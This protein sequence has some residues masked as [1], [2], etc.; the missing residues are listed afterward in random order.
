MDAAPSNKTTVVKP[1]VDPRFL[2]KEYG[3][4]GNDGEYFDDVYAE[5]VLDENGGSL[6]VGMHTINLNYEDILYS[7]QVVYRLA[8]GS[9]F[10]APRHGNPSGAFSVNIRLGPREHVTRLEGLYNGSVINQLSVSTASP[11]NVR[12]TYGPYGTP[13]LL[14]FSSSGHIIGFTG[15]TYKNMWNYFGIYKLQK[16][17]KTK[18]IGPGKGGSPFD[19]MND[20][21]IP[22]VLRLASLTIWHGDY[23]DGLQTRQTLLGGSTRVGKVFGGQDS[24]LSTTITLKEGEIIEHVD[25]CADDYISMLTFTIKESMTGLTKVVGPFGKGGNSTFSMYGNILGLYGYSGDLIDNLGFYFIPP[26]GY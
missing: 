11:D 7:I 15:R 5:P 13:A 16:I 22:P 9:L 19:D 14:R 24:T 2:S 1:N 17:N 26:R 21:K 8:N 18:L 4:G 25:M 3:P 23:I 20:L 10:H 6:V 12:K